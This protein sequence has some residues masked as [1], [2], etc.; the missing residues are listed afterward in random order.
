MTATIKQWTNIEL[1]CII[2]SPI[3]I[4]QEFLAAYGNYI[5]SCQ[6]GFVYLQWVRSAGQDSCRMSTFINNKRHHCMHWGFEIRCDGAIFLIWLE[7]LIFKEKFEDQSMSSHWVL[8]NPNSSAWARLFKLRASV[9][10]KKKEE[11]KTECLYKD[12][13]LL[14]DIDTLYIQPIW[15]KSGSNLRCLQRKISL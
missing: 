5:N 10:W 6:F 7:N 15:Q 2:E 4:H 8:K 3:E 9:N 1:F 12:V 11:K 13:I 14:Y